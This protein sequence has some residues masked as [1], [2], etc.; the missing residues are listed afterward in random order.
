MADDVE[1]RC[2]DINQDS[3]T[4]LVGPELLHQTIDKV[5]LIRERMKA[6]QSRQKSHADQGRRLL[7][8]VVG[9]HVYLWV[10]SPTSVYKR[11]SNEVAWG[12]DNQLSQNDLG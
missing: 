5:K 9:D 7:E 6:S 3:E 1:L 2:A 4:F 8:F 10:T 12:K 11:P